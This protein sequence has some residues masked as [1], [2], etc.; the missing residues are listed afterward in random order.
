MDELRILTRGGC[1]YELRLGNMI[2][3][4]Q[5]HARDNETAFR[6]Y[7]VVSRLCLGTQGPQMIYSGSLG[8][9]VVDS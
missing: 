9:E 8:K 7:L 3:N 6:V 5:N 2:L 1:R 4:F